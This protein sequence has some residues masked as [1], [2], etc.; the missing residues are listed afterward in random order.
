MPAKRLGELGR[1]AIPDPR[2]D[3]PHAEC[4]RLQHSR[5]ARHTDVGEMCPE[6]RVADLAVRTLQLTARSRDAPGDLIQ[7]EVAVVLGFDNRDGVAQE[8]PAQG[9][10]DGSM[11]RH[12]WYYGQFAKSDANAPKVSVK[13][14]IRHV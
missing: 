8:G 13:R 2:C 10:G 12:D 11:S 14:P 6:R 7:L 9:D 4:G 5:G 1:L 3:V